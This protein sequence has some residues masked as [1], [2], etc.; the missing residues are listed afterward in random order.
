MKRG[1][2]CTMALWLRT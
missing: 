2:Y 1:R